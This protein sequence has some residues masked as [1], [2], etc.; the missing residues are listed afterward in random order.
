VV[1]MKFA[2]VA[3]D[4]AGQEVRRALAGLLDRLPG[5]GSGDHLA[6]GELGSSCFGHW[7]AS[8]RGWGFL[9]ASSAGVTQ[10][11]FLGAPGAQASGTDSPSP[12]RHAEPDLLAGLRIL[13]PEVHVGSRLPA[14]VALVRLLGDESL[15]LSQALVHL[16]PDVG[17]EVVLEVAAPD[18]QLAP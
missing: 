5:A 13:G 10:G 3:G 17:E 18:L 8:P 11:G 7:I 6:E 14:A 9:A 1:V 16:R 15:R 4:V 12:A 2:P